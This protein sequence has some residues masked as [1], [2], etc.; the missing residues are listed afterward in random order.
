MSGLRV[1]NAQS[2]LRVCTMSPYLGSGDGSG[3]VVGVIECVD[4]PSGELIV[5]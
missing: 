1:S 2:L 3:E 5:L 4:V